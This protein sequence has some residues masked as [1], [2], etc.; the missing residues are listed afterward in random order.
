MPEAETW[1]A[2]A[3]HGRNDVYFYLDFASISRGFVQIYRVIQCVASCS[4]HATKMQRWQVVDIS[5][6]GGAKSTGKTVYI[7]ESIRSC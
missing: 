3:V 1:R 7:V 2:G 6:T 4:I 5:E